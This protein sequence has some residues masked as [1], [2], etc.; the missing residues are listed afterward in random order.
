MVQK[1]IFKCKVRVLKLER[2]K[3]SFVDATP[4]LCVCPS[5]FLANHYVDCSTLYPSAHSTGWGGGGEAIS[6]AQLATYGNTALAQHRV[7]LSAE[8][9]SIPVNTPPNINKKKV[10]AH[11]V[12]AHGGSRS[13]APLILILSTRGEWLTSYPGMEPI[14]QAYK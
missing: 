5:C 13:V 2:G 12:K 3:F 1:W 11:A 14:E 6:I 10:L 4:T 9:L 7:K 8:N